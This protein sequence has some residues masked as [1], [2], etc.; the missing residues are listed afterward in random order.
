MPASLGGTSAPYAATAVGV[1]LLLELVEPAA[2]NGGT[3]AP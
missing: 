3:V 2:S 1:E